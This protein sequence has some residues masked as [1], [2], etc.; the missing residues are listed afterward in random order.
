MYFGLKKSQKLPHPPLYQPS[1]AEQ[2]AAKEHIEDL[3]RSVK[4][5]RSKS[6]YCV[7]FFFVEEN[8]NMLKGFVDHS[9]VKKIMK[10]NN[11]PILITGEMFDQIGGI[12]VFSKTDF[13]TGFHQTRTKPEDLERNAF[14]TKYR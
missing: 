9:A 1:P 6:W 10:R 13:K 12:K 3:L 4:I 11:A 5:R 14:S 8:D 2:N 7:Q